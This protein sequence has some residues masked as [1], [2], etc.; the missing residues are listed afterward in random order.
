MFDVPTGSYAEPA[1]IFVKQ[2]RY[3]LT[4][5]INFET[6][7]PYIEGSCTVRFEKK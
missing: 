3:T 2:G 4:V 5:G 7:A 1:R 6:E